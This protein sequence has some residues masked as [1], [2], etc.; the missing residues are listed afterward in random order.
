[1]GLKH[2]PDTHRVISPKLALSF[3]ALTVSLLSC[4]PDTLQGRV[5]LSGSS[6]LAPLISQSVD[7][8]K[9]SHPLVDVRVEAI[10]SD[11]GLE[12]LIRYDD[13]DLAL[14]SRPLTEADQAAAAA[15]GKKLVALPLAWDAVAVVVPVSNTWAQSLTSDQAARAFTTA[16]LWSD[17]D[18]TWPAVA[19]HRFAL[20]PRSGT[21]DLFA[22]KL[23]AGQKGL[24][25][26]TS[27]VQSSEDDKILA[28][29]LAQVDGSIG[30]LGW[31]TVQ[32]TDLPLRALALDGVAPNPQTIRE[33]TYG[34]PRQLWLVG[35]N[36]TW[37]GQPAL[38]SLIRFLYAR[39]PQVLT[40]S[41]L[42]PLA[43]EE[44]RSVAAILN[45]V[46]N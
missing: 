41:A 45:Q 26:S 38:Q 35:V 34:L 33:G 10:G 17:L 40:G 8:W 6:T 27:A 30:Y 39:Y 13:A 46:L 22:A 32:E 15:V 3:L 44:L 5:I 16:K 31:T 42:V 12:R 43:D 7:Q 14:V 36:G 11:A 20:G 24:L 23:L 19:L 1:M 37:K 29:G 2:H 18:P 9:K 4:G 25:F 21:S 28:R